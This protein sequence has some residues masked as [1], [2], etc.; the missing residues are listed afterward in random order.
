MG[1]AFPGFPDGSLSATLL[2][3]LFFVEVLGEITDLAELKVTLYL[4]WRLGQ[5]KGYPRYVTRRDL[6]ADPTI[7][8]GLAEIPNGLAEGLAAAVERGTVLRRT[9]E[10]GGRAD[11]CYFLNTMAGRRAVTD[12]E[13]GA[14][15]LGQ[16]VRPEDPSDRQ[17]RSSAFRLYE[18]NV[19]LLTPLIVEQLAEAERTYP[20]EWIVEA[21]R[22]AA[23]YNRRNWRYIQRILER[24]ASEGRR[25]EASERR[26]GR[27]VSSRSGGSGAGRSDR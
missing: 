20:E 25:D 26:A 18:E 5:R 21:F 17:E 23:A 14:L 19:G 24:W 22:E 11:E 13:S 16:V 8:S 4:F 10:M 3:S 15:D 9:M 2:P 7:R 6:E 1:K 27:S 12:L